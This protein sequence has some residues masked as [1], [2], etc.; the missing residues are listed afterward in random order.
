MRS[1][2]EEKQMRSKMEE[3]NSERIVEKGPATRDKEKWRQ[4]NRG[5]E[6]RKMDGAAG[7]KGKLVV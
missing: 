6:E 2:R 3:T 7:A 4:V 5:G 1:E